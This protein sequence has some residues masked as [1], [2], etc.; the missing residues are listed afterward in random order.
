ML[1]VPL[2]VGAL[3]VQ[4]PRD[5][6]VGVGLQVAERQV[7]Q[8][9]L[10]LPD[11]EAVGQRRMDVA[12]QLRQGAPLRFG[13]PVGRAHPRQLPRQ[14]DRHHPQVAHDRQQQAAQ[15]LGAAGA[16]L[17]G[18]QRPDLGGRALA[19]DQQ[20][21][22][23]MGLVEGCAQAFMQPGQRMQQGRGHHLAVGLQPRQCLEGACNDLRRFAH[24]NRPGVRVRE[25][26]AHGRLQRR[27]RG[28]CQQRPQRVG[29][30]HRG[31]GGVRGHACNLRGELRTLAADRPEEQA[32]PSIRRIIAIALLCALPSLAA[33]QSES[34][35]PDQRPIEQRMTPEEFRAAGLDKLG[36]DELAAL[37]AWLR[38]TLQAE[39]TRAAAQAEKKVKD[40]NRGFLSFGSEEPIVAR[41]P[42]QFTGFARGR[43][44][45]LDNGQVWEQ[46]DNASIPGARL[47]DPE[48]RIRPAV[49]GNVWYMR[50]QG[51][52]TNAKVKRVK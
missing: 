45:V 25:R 24:A 21:D 2:A 16:A 4:Q 47:T 1:D 13:Q 3:F 7:L 18:M 51:Y 35:P 46:V 36:P 23:R 10:Q 43:R 49:L 6:L 15:A 14:Q 17:F 30:Q 44:Y 20:R 37:N 50:V 28:R 29:R 39:T 26:F 42:G 12:R 40:E 8:F 22:R 38:G 41:I 19:L 27:G 48:V 34:Q 5:A 32:M 31:V 33:A 9:P 52:S 11:A